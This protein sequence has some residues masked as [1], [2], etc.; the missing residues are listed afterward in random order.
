LQKQ[1]NI[2]YSW[3]KWLVL[4]APLAI[5]WAFSHQ[6][7]PFNFSMLLG[8]IVF[9]FVIKFQNQSSN[10]KYA[11]LAGL[12]SIGLLLVRTNSLYYFSAVFLM[13]F[14]L[15]KW[16]GKINILPFLLAVVI[17]PTINT[18]V[19]I[20]SFP[21]RLKL[22]EWAGATLKM[23]GIDIEVQGNLLLLEG[24]TFAVDPACIGL[25]LIITAL[26]LSIV[27]LAYFEK[28]HQKTINFWQ[29]MPVLFLVL[30][31]TILANFIR[32]LTLIIF[33]ILPENPLHDAVGMLSLVVY[34]LIPMYF[35]IP[36]YFKKYIK[37]VNLNS[38]KIIS[39][40]RISYVVYSILLVLIIINGRQ[41]LEQRIENK[42]AIEHIQFANLDRIVTELGVLKLENEEALI[43][44]KPPV[45]FFQGSHDPR[46]CWQ[47]SGYDFS[48][49]E[50][51]N[52]GD[53]QLYIA[54]LTK[55]NDKIYTAWWYQSQNSQTPHEWNWRLNNLKNQEAFYMVNV[56]CNDKATLKKWIQ[57]WS[58][59]V[60]L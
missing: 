55:E 38:S 33:H 47:G 18:I 23:V 2:T 44:V 26:V 48:E 5:F 45:R 19:Y 10:F 30:F 43:Y 4:F 29:S 36:F 1:Q 31:A 11:I 32:L 60:K 6:N 34:V 42:S 54:L 53:K 57:K 17:S 35:F 51:Q 41:F 20:W 27:I 12:V 9:P 16:F 8:I 56:N 3:W 40:N 14:V 58:K 13:L 39:V 22:S 59:A 25:K 21:I 28:K 7:M 52:F 50:I 49:V 46:F 24:N 37:N 15:D